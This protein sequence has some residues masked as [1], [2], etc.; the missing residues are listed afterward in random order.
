MHGSTPRVLFSTLLLAPLPTPAYNAIPFPDK[1]VHGFR[2]NFIVSSDLVASCTKHIAPPTTEVSFQGWYHSIL[3]PRLEIEI[4]I[5]DRHLIWIRCSSS[6][7]CCR[8]NLRCRRLISLVKFASEVEREFLYLMRIFTNFTLKLPPS[9]NR[10]CWIERKHIGM[11]DTKWS[12]QNCDVVT[13]RCGRR[14]NW[15]AEGDALSTF[16]GK[17]GGE[18]AEF[19]RSGA[20]CKGGGIVARGGLST[21][22]DGGVQ[23]TWKAEIVT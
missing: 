19:G 20:G 11:V 1:N 12:K 13:Y 2:A 17:E 16:C 22:C 4:M 6:G 23:Q 3:L 10:M 21:N 15:G 7:W 5:S 14:C 18:G 8:V 9:A